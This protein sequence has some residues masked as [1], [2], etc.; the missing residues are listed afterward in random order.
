MNHL[1]VKWSGETD[2]GG[3][4]TKLK[5]LEGRAKGVLLDIGAGHGSL[6][7]YLDP[8]LVTH[9]VALEPNSLMHP[10][11]RDAAAAAGFT[12][13][14][15]N[16]TLLPIGLEDTEAV[17]ILLAN[18]GIK[19]IDTAVSILCFCSCP[20]PAETIRRLV[21]ELIRPNGGQLLFYEHT[22]NEQ[23]EIARLQA[24]ATKVWSV[25]LDHCVLG[26]DT[27]RMI[28]EAD[29][30]ASV[31]VFGKRDENKDSLFIHYGGICIRK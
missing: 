6:A 9:Y 22:K 30:W 18:A 29:D 8:Q 1:W 23:E 7:G 4:E 3:R 20:R 5:L 16:F 21:E 19:H 28:R 27:V 11:L 13:A 14:K 31:E 25:L 10:I 26:Q 17:K 24:Q 2:A 12:A 15:G